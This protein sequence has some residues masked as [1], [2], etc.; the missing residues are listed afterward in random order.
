M[1]N[2]VSFIQDKSNDSDI[3]LRLERIEEIL[4]MIQRQLEM[5]RVPS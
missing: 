2:G 1:D 3:I 5:L 4:W